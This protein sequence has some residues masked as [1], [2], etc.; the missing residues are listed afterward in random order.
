MNRFLFR[1]KKCIFYQNEGGYQAT[2][3]QETPLDEIYFLGIIDI[4]TPY[5]LKKKL[6]TFFK[7]LRYDKVSDVLYDSVRF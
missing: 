2:S 6:E 1:R 3:N 7:G 5:N 4:L